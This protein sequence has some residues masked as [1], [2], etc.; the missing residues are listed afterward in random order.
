MKDWHISSESFYNISKSN[1]YLF[2]FKN[3]SESWNCNVAV[4]YFSIFNKNFSRIFQLQWNIWN[5]PDIFL[6]YAVLCGMCRHIRLCNCKMTVNIFGHFYGHSW[7]R[8]YNT[9][10]TH[11]P[12]E[13]FLK[14][15]SEKNL[16]KTRNSI[17]RQCE[18]F[19]SAPTVDE[20]P[21]NAH[22][23]NRE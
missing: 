18:F 3:I 17:S 4:K 13:I 7:W 23:T 2:V 6:E 16:L 22:R 12:G 20:T 19:S 10:E 9:G 11:T 21:K 15:G 14:S 8:R 5:I 1:K